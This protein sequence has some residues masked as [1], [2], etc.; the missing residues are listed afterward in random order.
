MGKRI[1]WDL[2]RAV[3]LL[4]QGHTCREI[5]D[6]MGLTRETGL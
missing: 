3:D 5:S 4:K 6:I 1:K 2:D